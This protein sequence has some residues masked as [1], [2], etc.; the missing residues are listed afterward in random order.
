VQLVFSD[1]DSLVTDVSPDGTR[2]LYSTTKEDSDLWGVPV[3][4]GA[5]EFQVTSDIGVEFW[6]EIAPD[7]ERIVYQ[8][9]Q[10]SSGS[11]KLLHSS[12]VT[13]K[14][15]GEQQR[16]EIAGDGFAARWSPDGRQTAFLRTEAGVNTLWVVSASGG[17]ARAVTS[18]GVSFGGYSLLP[19]NRVQTQDFEWSADS[20]LLLY[21]AVR[22]G[23]SNLW[24]AAV[25]EVQPGEK[26]LTRNEDK[27][28]LFFNPTFAPDTSGRVA[29]LAMSVG[30]AGDEQKKPGWSVWVAGAGGSPAQIYQSTSPLGL[31]GWSSDASGLI[32]KAVEQGQSFSRQPAP[33]AILRI[34][35][36]TGGAPREL[37]KL[38]NVYFQNIRLSPDKK[39][40]AFAARAGDNDAIQIAPFGA[41]AAGAPKTLVES[42]DSRV[43]F[44]SLAFAPDGKTLYYGKQANWQ[45]ISMITNFK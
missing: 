24:Q 13:Q 4:G 17:D 21:S 20:R 2:I 37:L 25:G 22:N 7:G 39:T 16:T 9:T 26:Q 3:Q 42:S 8:T 27:N 31:L 14:I 23:V 11:S 29:W 40:L 1:S 5:R 45:V 35:A 28:L 34:D 30:G 6:Q 44:S 36:A 38:N 41:P 15:K 32:L 43:Y 18:G 33:V 10:T 19:Y 12:L